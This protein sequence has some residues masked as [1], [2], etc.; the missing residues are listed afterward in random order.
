MYCTMWVQP[1]LWLS[2]LNELVGKVAE[3][4]ANLNGLA[5]EACQMRRIEVILYVQKSRQ[6]GLHLLKC[7]VKL[8]RHDEGRKER[9]R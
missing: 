5:G 4:S 6:V 7:D 2:S 3:K 9:K 8:A 1:T